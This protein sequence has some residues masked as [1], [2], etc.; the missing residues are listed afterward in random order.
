V[1]DLP[2]GKTLQNQPRVTMNVTANNE[3]E[4]VTLTLQRDLTDEKFETYLRGGVDGVLSDEGSGPQAFFVSQIAKD[5]GEGDWPD[6]QFM[7]SIANVGSNGRRYVALLVILGRP[8]AIGAMT[9]NTEKYL[10]GERRNSE[11][12]IIDFNYLGHKDDKTRLL[13]G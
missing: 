8:K 13:E 11:L 6:L 1:A 2:V 5:A 3:A 12:A 10:K 9:L 7:R 4:M